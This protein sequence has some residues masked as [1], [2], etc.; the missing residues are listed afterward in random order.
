M[1]DGQKTIVVRGKNR[2]SPIKKKKKPQKKQE[3]QLEPY[4]DEV[5]RDGAWNDIKGRGCN[6]F[7]YSLHSYLSLRKKF[8]FE[9]IK[10]FEINENL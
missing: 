9:N 2:R 1:I 7:L 3:S 6:Y 4:Q 5:L 10:T 8:D